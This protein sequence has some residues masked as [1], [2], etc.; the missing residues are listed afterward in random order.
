MIGDKVH[1]IVTKREVDFPFVVY[2]RDS[3]AVEYDKS[4][5]ATV[6][7]TVNVYVLAETYTESVEIAE[8][9]IKS[10]NRVYADYDKF[11]VI[12]ASLTGAN[13]DYVSQT[14]VQQLTFNFLIQ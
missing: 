10:L 9:V 5:K 6:A 13:E 1:P 4:G 12:G 14:Y 3:I 11:A 8:E 7:T 2:K